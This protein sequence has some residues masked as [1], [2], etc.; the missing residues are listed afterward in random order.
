M[1]TVLVSSVKGGTGKSLIASCLALESAQRGQPTVLIDADIDSPNLSEILRVQKQLKIEKDKIEI[2]SVTENLDFFSMGLITKGKAVSMSGD[3]YV[4]ILNDILA[5]GQFNV[6]VENALVVIDTPAGASDIFRAVLKS[7]SNSIVGGVIVTQ[8]SALQD[9]RRNANIFNY[10][11]VPIIAIVE[12]MAYFKCE[13]GKKFYIFG[14]PKAKEL[15]E[16]LGVDYYQVPLSLNIK[17]TIEAGLPFVPDDLIDVIDALLGKIEMLEPA[18]ES[19]TEKLSK[20]FK[21]VATETLANV[22]KLAI[23]RANKEID[24]RKVTDLGFG[25]RTIEFIITDELEEELLTFYG[26]L[27]GDKFVI[28]KRPKKVD[29]TVIFP[30]STLIKVAKEEITLEDAYYMGEI[31]V[32]GKGGSIR[33]LRFMEEVWK[34]VKDEILNKVAPLFKVL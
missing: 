16:T 30:V 34:L 17:E 13:C 4:Q 1:K 7:F 29:I 21:K 18:K 15:A 32:Y 6:D 3:S 14:E 12:N 2:A 33:A 26:R 24:L 27:E 22:V 20:K 9:A 11:G 5:H 28:V 25:G 31:E 19:I 10:F 8:P 23:L